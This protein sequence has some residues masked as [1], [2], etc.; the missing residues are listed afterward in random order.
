[1][2][3]TWPSG[4]Y[5]TWLVGMP[6]KEGGGGMNSGLVGLHLKDALTGE[7]LPRSRN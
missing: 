1:M 6:D 7:L 3:S 2:C 5:D 4:D